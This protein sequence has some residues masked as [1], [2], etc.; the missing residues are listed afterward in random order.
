MTDEN[1]AT[2]VVTYGQALV[3]A[4]QAFDTL[5]TKAGWFEEGRPVF[6]CAG[7]SAISS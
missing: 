1:T 3:K 5:E 2:Q 4:L 6:S 7:P